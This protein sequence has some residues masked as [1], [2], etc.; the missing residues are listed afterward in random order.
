MWPSNSLKRQRPKIGSREVE[1]LLRR[2]RMNFGGGVDCEQI[3]EVAALA[4]GARG[5]TP[6][7]MLI[8]WVQTCRR[9][10]AGLSAYGSG[11]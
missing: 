5:W 8:E 1:V 4:G 3:L 7:E 11:E 10:F 6:D 2:V 9:N